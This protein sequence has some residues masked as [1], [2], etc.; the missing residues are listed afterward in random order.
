M[1]TQLSVRNHTLVESLDIE[2]NS[3]LS[4]ITGETGAGK[5]ILLNALGLTLGDRADFDQVRSGAKRA[6]INASFDISSLESA[7]KFL[8]EQALDDDGECILR[9]VINAN[10]SSKAWINGQPVTLSILRELAEQLISIHSQHEHQALLR[11][12]T[13]QEL[14]DSYAKAKDIVTK[15]SQ[16][17]HS[18]SSKVLQLADL[19]SNM[20]QY[21]QRKELLK[22]QYEELSSLNLSEG[23]FA[24]LEQEQKQL[25][26]AEQIQRTLYQASSILSEDD[27]FNVLSGIRQIT[28]LT[29]AIDIDNKNLAESNQLLIDGL[30]QLEEARESLRR[31][32]D[33]IQMDPERLT[34]VDARLSAA[35][36]LARKHRCEP[37]Q[38]PSITA[39]MQQEID[40]LGDLD[41]GLDSLKSEITTL[42]S[43]YKALAAKLGKLRIKAAKQLG[44]EV[45]AHFNELNMEGAELKIEL[46]QIKPSA[47]GLE[48]CSFLIR[49]NPGQ[50]HKPLARIASG[51]ELSRV[52][53]AIQV[54]TASCSHSPTLVFDEVDVGIGGAT[55]TVV[56][57][58]LRSLGKHA[59]VICVTHLAQVASQAHH[60]LS[61][62][63]TSTDTE[64]RTDIKPIE[65]N[66]RR[67]E[68]ARMLSGNTESEHS[69]KHAE[70]LLSI[71]QS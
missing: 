33:Q 11:T 46:E 57:Q 68:I 48:Q 43:S 17:Y 37:D 19:E 47:K 8:E 51:G 70:E 56:G 49:T 59:Q 25:A 40:Q 24:S 38:L 14:L 60:H 20:E 67:A 69:L 53:L 18:W 65:Q 63:K 45:Q 4:A 35:F 5:S 42:E 22:F 10:G 34:E 58:K 31:T 52:S 44:S 16:A 50:S 36:D 30:S 28:Q 15:T 64:T 13:Q 23:E 41:S 26:N 32:S 3:R 55:A 29:Q 66:D 61:V 12:E 27:S 1:L 71:A 6:E 39:N 9:R 2:F 54:V 21:L 7:K 62:S